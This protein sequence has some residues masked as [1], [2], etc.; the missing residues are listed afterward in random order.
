MTAI[1]GG[2]LAINKVTFLGNALTLGGLVSFL[3]FNKNF[4]MPINQI[5]QQVNAIVMALAGADRIF[6]L[7]DETPETDNGYVTLVNAKFE[8]D[9]L[10]EAKEKTGIWAWKHIHQADGTV[11]YKQLKGDVVFDDVDFGY[12]D[13]KIVLH[14]VDLFATPGQKIAFVGSTGQVK[15]L[16]QILLIDFMIFRM[17]KS[18]MMVLT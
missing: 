6:K 15:Q 10:V 12:N 2:F 11:E 9:K 3:T 4:S 1:V 5:S 13:D 18:D 17:E 7:L 14:N 16:S 8:G